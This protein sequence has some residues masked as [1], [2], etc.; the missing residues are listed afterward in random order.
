MS[1]WWTYS[2]SDFLMFS[3]RAYWRLFEQ[4]LGAHR[5]AMWPLLALLLA[6]WISRRPL[7]AQRWAGGSA[8]LAG[9]CL[10]VAWTFVVQRLGSIHWAMPNFAWAIATH[11]LL[12]CFV[13][14][15]TLLRR[16]HRVNPR[17]AW[18]ILAL[19]IGYPLAGVLL[20]RQWNQIEFLGLTPDLTLLCT[21]VI[22]ACLASR[23]RW[24]LLPVPLAWGL[25]SAAT[26]WTLA[27]K[28]WLMMLGALAVC[29]WAVWR[30]EPVGRLVGR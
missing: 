21:L 30:V 24:L 2:L 4:Q 15:D 23:W 12:I 5:Y 28:E 13:I 11:A 7:T 27:S 14:G 17:A 18:L 9:A 25:F 26:L 1:E 29:L 6:P 8:L 22:P 20:G 19:A 3:P 10:W 16:P